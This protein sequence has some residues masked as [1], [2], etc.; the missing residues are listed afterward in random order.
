MHVVGRRYSGEYYGFMDVRALKGGVSRAPLLLLRF[1][2]VSIPCF[3]ASGME[4]SV[5]KGCWGFQPLKED[6]SPF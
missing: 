2:E 5:L 1:L 6:S 3:R 4:V